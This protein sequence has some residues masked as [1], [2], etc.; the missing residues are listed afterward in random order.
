VY[1]NQRAALPEQ[2][3]THAVLQALVTGLEQIF[4]GSDLLAFYL[5][6]SLA[7]GDFNAETSDLDFIIITAGAISDEQFAGLSA[8]HAR[9]WDANTNHLFRRCEGDYLT[10]EQAQHPGPGIVCP[11]LGRDGHFAVEE[12]GSE[13]VI[14]LWKVLQS[15]FVV[16][17]P[18]PSELIAPISDER[19]IAA[20]VALFSGWWLPKLESRE[21]MS[22]AY[23]VYAVLTMARILYGLETCGETSKP[24]AAEWLAAEQP[25]FADL[26]HS[27]LRWRKGMSFDSHEAVF[28]LMEYTRLVVDTWETNH[29]LR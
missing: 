12:H 22:P 5:G 21:P 2:S 20:K 26:L 23:Q 9:I 19:M 11:H 28:A 8:M 1:I 4:G 16:F 27:A 24:R 15:G 25:L 18:P 10:L 7:I 6:G 29:P 17:G 14:D 13:L 3:I